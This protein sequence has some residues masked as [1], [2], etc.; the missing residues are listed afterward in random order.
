MSPPILSPPTVDTDVLSSSIHVVIPPTPIGISQVDRERS[1]SDPVTLCHPSHLRPQTPSP[2]ATEISDPL[3]T[4][5]KQSPK[6][7][8]SLLRR[9]SRSGH[10]RSSSIPGELRRT[11]SDPA[12][13]SRR[14]EDDDI[15]PFVAD[16]LQQGMEMLRVTRKGITKRICWIDPV[17]ACVAWDSKNSSK[18]IFPVTI[19]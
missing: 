14:E 4:H 5:W 1:F 17:R 2:P 15:V 9:L 7:S 16:K 3:E 12:P 10:R 13:D 8:S 11:S 6:R 18:R 19:C